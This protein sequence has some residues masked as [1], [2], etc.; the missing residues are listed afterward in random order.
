MKLK[1]K[2]LQATEILEG[3]I[4]LD[5]LRKKF[6]IPADA[7]VTISTPFI[8]E[9]VRAYCH[10]VIEENLEIKIRVERVK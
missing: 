8:E 4:T 2:E 1:R 6:N 9:E 7:E 5:M 3:T 10:D